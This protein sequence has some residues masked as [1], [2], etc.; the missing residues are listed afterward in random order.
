MSAA[1]LSSAQDTDLIDEVLEALRADQNLQGELGTPARIYD[2]ETEAPAYPY[3]MLD[4]YERTDTSVSQALCAE[5]SFQFVCLS[6]T[7]G[8][9]EAK[10][11]LSR[12]RLA[13]QRMQLHPNGLRVVLIHPTYSDVMRARNQRFLRGVLRVRIHTEEI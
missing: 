2:A 5:H 8:Q 10:R 7:G 3:V 12:L 1:S 4:R 9:S 13:L 6:N 11:L